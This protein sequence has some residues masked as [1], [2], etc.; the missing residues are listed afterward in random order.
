MI[1]LM[2]LLSRWSGGLL[3]R[4]GAKIPLMV[5]PLIAAAG[6]F[7]FT[8][9]DVGARYWSGFFPGFMV[10]GLG[11]AISVA[12]LTTVVMNSVEQERVGTASGINNAVARIAGVL[13]VAIL[14][15]VMVAAFAHALRNSLSDLNLSAN[16][17]HELESNVA[18]LGSLDAPRGTD[19]QTATTIHSV[20]AEAFLFAF[21]R[22]ML[23][24]A[25]FAIAGAAIAW[26]KIP[27]Q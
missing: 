1:L 27:S 17:V 18:R 24:C 2:F 9:P 16:I 23:L 5:G 10:L 12:P 13:A 8:V 26:R 19:P 14:R 22:I 6:F 25:G 21:R 7:L 3:T 20:V 11:M 4:Y 15:V